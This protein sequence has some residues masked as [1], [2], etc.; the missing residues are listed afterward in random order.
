MIKMIK[1]E[2]KE[3]QRRNFA[4]SKRRTQRRELDE[5]TNMPNGTLRERRNAMKYALNMD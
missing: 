2:K 1:R 3:Y 4:R 5:K